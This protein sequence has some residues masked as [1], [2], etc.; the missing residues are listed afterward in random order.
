MFVVHQHVMAL[1]IGVDDRRFARVQETHAGHNV[2]HVVEQGDALKG[3]RL[4]V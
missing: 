3:D 1:E 4:V 2:P